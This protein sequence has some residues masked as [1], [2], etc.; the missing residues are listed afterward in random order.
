MGREP[1]IKMRID[2]CIDMCMNMC[3][4]MWGRHVYI[5]MRHVLQMDTSISCEFYE[6]E[7]AARQP[8]HDLRPADR[9]TVDG[10][11]QHR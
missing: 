3:M 4:N 11:P 7:L 6:P 10:P 9:S 2:M 5:Q 1:K 8:L